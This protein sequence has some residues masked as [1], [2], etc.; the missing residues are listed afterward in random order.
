MSKQ[1]AGNFI[2]DSISFLKSGSKKFTSKVN[3]ILKTYGNTQIESI[4]IC[5][6]PINSMIKKA[7][8]IAS[9]STIQYDQLFH[10]YMVFNG[11]I[12]LEKNSVVNMS[13]NPNFASDTETISVHVPSNNM[14]INQFIQ[15]GLSNIGPDK[16]F[17]YSAYDNNCQVFIMNLLHANGIQDSDADNFIKQD[18]ESIFSSNPTLRRLTNN[19][20]D[21]DGRAHELMGGKLIENLQHHCVNNLSKQELAS[22]FHHE[23]GDCHFEFYPST[24][25]LIKNKIMKG[26]GQIFGST[27]NKSSSTVVPIQTQPNNLNDQLDDYDDYYLDLDFQKE[28]NEDIRSSLPTELTNSITKLRKFKKQNPQYRKA[29][30]ERHRINSYNKKNPLNPKPIPSETQEILKKGKPYIDKINKQYQKNHHINHES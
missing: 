18:T 28:S 1:K 8:E 19:V 23:N 12:L 20:T 24:H 14:T 25:K 30:K 7:L 26:G 21:I 16:F 4:T 2:S 13:I 10:L 15:N 6:H 11:N 22:L 9:W 5:R 3:K 29:Q 17:T 27:K